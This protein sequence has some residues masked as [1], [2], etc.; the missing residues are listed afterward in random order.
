MDAKE[1][2]KKD[3]L[4]RMRGRE[5]VEEWQEKGAREYVAGQKTFEG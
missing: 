3:S 5:G 1:R 2:D 4:A